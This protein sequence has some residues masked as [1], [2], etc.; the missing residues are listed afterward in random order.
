V[1]EPAHDFTPTPRELRGFDDGR[2][3]SEK[4][5]QNTTPALQQVN[6]KE[7][8]PFPFPSFGWEKRPGGKTLVTRRTGGRRTRAVALVTNG[9][10]GRGKAQKA[11]GQQWPIKPRQRKL[12]GPLGHWK[13]PEKER[14][15]RSKCVNKKTKPSMMIWRGG[16]DKRN[17]SQ[18]NRQKKNA[19]EKTSRRREPSVS[20]GPNIQRGKKQRI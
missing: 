4:A 13:M 11:K 20:R 5:P 10:S 15:L 19:R 17:A 12:V 7:E 18:A 2:R 16:K 14:G 8:R 9:N 3:L 6:Q 1:K